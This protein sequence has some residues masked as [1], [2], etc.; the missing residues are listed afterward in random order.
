MSIKLICK[1]LFLLIFFSGCFLFS[2][3]GKLDLY[4][5]W[6]DREIIIDGKYTDWGSSSTYYYEKTRTVLNLANDSDYMYICL[7]SRN[8]EV[9]VQIMES[10]LFVWFDP[11]AKKEKTFGIRFPVGLKRAGVSLQDKD[12]DITRDWEDQVDKSEL[13]DR[14]QE[15]FTSKE[16][17]KR[18]ETLES[19]QERLEIVGESDHFKAKDKRLKPPLEEFGKEEIRKKMESGDGFLKDGPRE[20]SLEEAKKLG[21]EAKVGRENGYFVYELKIPLVKSVSHPHA[22]ELKPNRVIGL[23]L[24]IAGS[25]GGSGGGI[26]SGNGGDEGDRMPAGGM[27]SGSGRHSGKSLQLWAIVT[28]P[29]AA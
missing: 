7:I 22:I 25:M 5:S 2:G 13:I 29:S 27:D 15:R 9:E 23:G 26:P 19:L 4:S 16:F 1:Q 18:L 6:R 21:I 28:L 12:R 24:E 3:C 8:R 17:N 20:I 11:G 14:D 10:G